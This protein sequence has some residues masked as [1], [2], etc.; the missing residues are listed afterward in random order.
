MTESI[1]DNM[2]KERRKKTLEVASPLPKPKPR[3]RP[4]SLASLISSENSLALLTPEQQRK[5]RDAEPSSQLA[6]LA[7]LSVPSLT[8]SARAGSC[9]RLTA[10]PDGSGGCNLE[11]KLKTAGESASSISFS[12]A[13]VAIPFPEPVPVRIDLGFFSSQTKPQGT[14][15]WLI[16]NE[17]GSEWMAEWVAVR[18]S[19]KEVDGSVPEVQYRRVRGQCHRFRPYLAYGNYLSC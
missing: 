6:D 13:A 19:G 2:P 15:M 14:F 7:Q 18:T 5:P 4:P 16:R 8:S 9:E 12:S 11:S 3:S 17:G 1:Y 10:C